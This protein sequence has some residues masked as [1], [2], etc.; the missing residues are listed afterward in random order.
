MYFC[1]GFLKVECY[2]KVIVVEVGVQYQW[3]IVLFQKV[4]DEDYKVIVVVVEVEQYIF[5]DSDWV[6]LLGLSVYG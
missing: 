5:G 3:R 4:G 6:D 1:V 2:V